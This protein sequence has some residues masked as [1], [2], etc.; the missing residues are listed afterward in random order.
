MSP[1]VT[2][3]DPMLQ[4]LLTAAGIPY[5]SADQDAIYAI[6][7]V[8]YD[9]A[10]YTDATHMFR[11]LALVAPTR[12][13]SWASLAACHEALGDAERARILYALALDV[14]ERDNHRDV[15]AVYK[16]R[17]DLDAGDRE[18]A[19]ETLAELDRDNLD[20]ALLSIVTSIEHALWRR[21][22]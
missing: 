5:T 3:D 14:D 20:P 6:G 2:R 22:P 1:A 16:A 10:D 13:R 11:L 4:S 12:S 17:L 21:R 9:R 15:A 19:G 7:R 18:V 8:L